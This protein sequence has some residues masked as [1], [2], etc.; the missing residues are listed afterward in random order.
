MIGRFFLVAWFALLLGCSDPSSVQGEGAV[1]NGPD[2]SQLKLTDLNGQQIELSQYAGKHLVINFW[3][4]WCAPCREEM[5]ALQSLSEQLDADRYR[6]IGITVDQNQQQAE[7]FLAEHGISFQQYF[8]PQM[9]L[10]MSDLKIRAF[11]ETLI[12]SAD[13]TLLRRILGARNWDDK[14]YYQTILPE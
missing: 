5:P 9:A 3:A 8:D 4:T 14:S 12:V 1:D 6:V 11:P 7:T 10:A 13:G 2:L